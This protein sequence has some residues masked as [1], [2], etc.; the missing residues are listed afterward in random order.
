MTP[1]PP[2]FPRNTNGLIPPRGSRHIGYRP[3][4]TAAAFSS[5]GARSFPPKGRPLVRLRDGV[6]FGNAG[7]TPGAA[8]VGRRGGPARA[9][10]PGAYLHAAG[11]ASPLSRACPPHR[12]R[13]DLASPDSRLSSASEPLAQQ[14]IARTCG[15]CTL[16]YAIRCLEGGHEGGRS[17][18][19]AV[20]LARRA[21]ASSPATRDR[22]CR[23]LEA[24]RRP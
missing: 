14:S 10:S 17:C 3:R 7:C 20:S 2:P 15:E 19:A 18:E 1:L 22:P 4:D 9:D 8:C 12:P 16:L 11:V 6:C 24:A 21:P 5:T 23:P 13:P